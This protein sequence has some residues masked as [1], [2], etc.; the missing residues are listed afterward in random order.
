MLRRALAFAIL[1]GCGTMAKVPVEDLVD[2]IVTARC[3][4]AIACL[5]MPDAATCQALRPADN[6]LL[7][8]VADIRSGLIAYDPVLGARC[9][10][11][12]RAKSCGFTGGPYY[13]DLVGYTVRVDPC[14]EMLQGQSPNGGICN[15]NAACA[16]YGQCFGPACDRSMTCCTGTCTAMPLVGLGA[17]CASAHCPDDAYCNVNDGAP[18]DRIDSCM[19]PLTCDF[20]THGNMGTCTRVPASA[21][22]PPRVPIGAACDEAAAV[23]VGWAECLGGVCVAGLAL[24]AT[25]SATTSGVPTCFGDALCVDSVC[26]VPQTTPCP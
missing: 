23:C 26:T 22:T 19:P 7:S 13:S 25:C 6:I 5:D 3:D 18:C 9:V 12:I 14:L 1:A 8:I 17:P 24:G 4:H 2:E 21:P 11:E 15:E 10:D 20:P 16:E